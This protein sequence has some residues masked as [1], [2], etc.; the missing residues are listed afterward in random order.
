MNKKILT[1]LVLGFV[2]LGTTGCGNKYKGQGT[3]LLEKHGDVVLRV[4]RGDR[5]GKKDCV[6]VELSLYDDN[7]YELFTDSATCKPWHTCTMQL[8]YTKSIKGSYDYDLLKI[9]EAS[10]NADDKTYSKDN[11]PEYR[12]T[13]G[14][15]YIDKYDSLTFTVEKGQTNKYLDELL[16]ELNIDLNQCLNPDYVK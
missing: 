14:K 9:I 12:L 1:I 6:T 11:L 8:I 10:T 15:K 7:Q 16:N 5:G 4:K 3:E 2:V 13:L